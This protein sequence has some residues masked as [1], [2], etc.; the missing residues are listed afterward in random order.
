MNVFS[1]MQTFITFPALKPSKKKKK[2]VFQRIGWDWDQGMLNSSKALLINCDKIIKISA[3]VMSDPFPWNISHMEQEFSFYIKL[4]PG[5]FCV[6]RTT[7]TPAI[8]EGSRQEMNSQQA[9]ASEDKI[10]WILCCS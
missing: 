3:A 2:S 10:P 5:D 9:A 8:P 1:L 7:N 6:S 4:L